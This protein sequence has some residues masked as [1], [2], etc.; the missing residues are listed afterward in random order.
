MNF[1][2][3]LIALILSQPTIYSGVVHAGNTSA[4][5]NYDKHIGFITYDKGKTVLSI[6]NDDLKIGQK[7]LVLYKFKDD[8]P[9][10]LEATII[11][12]V[13]DG[14]V[15]HKAGKSSERRPTLYKLDHP[16]MESVAFVP[17]IGATKYNM[18]EYTIDIDGD[19]KNESLHTCTSMEGVHFLVRSGHPRTGVLRKDFY[20]YLGYDVEPSCQDSDF[21]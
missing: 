18:K 1:I 6:E 9:H 15:G 3:I 21:N 2:R 5:F 17:A 12:Q 4:R 10:I 14:T 19:G 20:H 16:Q 11:E 7:L 8:K 13:S